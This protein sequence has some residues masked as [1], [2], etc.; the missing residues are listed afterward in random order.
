MLRHDL[1]QDVVVEILSRLPVKSL[2]RF[3]CVHKSW[4][5]L[6]R[7]HHFITKHHKFATSNNLGRG[8]LFKYRSSKGHLCVSLL[9]NDTLEVSRDVD[10]LS[11]FPD[12]IDYLPCIYGPCNGIFLLQGLYTMGDNAE[13]LVLWNPATRETKVLP[14]IKRGCRYNSG[15]HLDC[16]FGF[17]IDPN[18]NDYKV[19]RIVDCHGCRQQPQ[20]EV[21]N[22][23]TDSWRVIDRSPSKLYN[24]YF[25][26]FPSYLNGFH[27][28]KAAEV[29]KKARGKGWMFPEHGPTRM[30]I[31]SFDMS[32]EVFLE[33]PLPT[34]PCALGSL[35]NDIAVINDSVS[36]IVGYC[37]TRN[38]RNGW[39]DIW[40][41]SSEI[42]VERTWTKKF[43]VEGSGLEFADRLLEIRED[44]LVILHKI[45][46][47]MAVYDRKTQELRK[48]AKY[49]NHCYECLAVTYT[50]TLVFMNGGGNISE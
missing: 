14:K 46:G 5:A 32:N 12:K 24:I 31:V 40:V 39:F 38:L 42:G 33:T 26:R 34:V 43:K 48:F 23:S 36:L 19:V 10:L 28:W 13:D 22:L 11:L 29:Y 20:F 1:P 4:Y 50:E 44:G 18:T 9:S 41:M 27:H 15:K 47:S 6:M 35:K 2:M 7:S 21:Y 49:G 17:G 45:D 8:V 37:G 25:S 3:N 16:K 30:F